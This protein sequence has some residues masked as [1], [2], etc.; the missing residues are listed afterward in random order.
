MKILHLTAQKPD[1]TGSG[2]YLAET[3]AACA[4]AGHEQAVICGIGPDDQP[5][6]PEGVLV[7][8]V[9][10]EIDDLPFPVVGM[11]D[12]MPYPATRYRD[13]TPEMVAQFK[14]EFTRALDDVLARFE[15][16]LT[17][18]NHLYLLTALVAHH[19]VPG[20]LAGLSHG[21][22]I[23]Q[24]EKIPLERAYIAEGVRSLDR[25]F[26]LH[27]AQAEDITRIYGVDADRIRVVGCGFNDR[28][29]K[30]VADDALSFAASGG[31]AAGGAAAAKPD[32]A[33]AGEPAVSTGAAPSAAQ[34][35]SDDG[36]C[37]ADDKA[38]VPAD[39][40]RKPG[41]IVYAGKIW[42]KKGVRSLIR[43]LD[44][45]DP[46]RAARLSVRLAGGYN[47]RDEYESIVEQ[48]RACAVPCTFLGKLPQY[49]L[50]REY[51]AADVFVLPSFFE[52]LPLVVVEALACGCKVVV[53]DL[54]G[55]RPW[56][57]EN[58]PGAPMRY[59]EPPR[60]KNADDPNPEDLPRFERD[61]ARALEQALDDE[62]RTV[63]VSRLSWDGLAKRLI[64][65]R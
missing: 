36:T 21:T 12:V 7:V 32:G 45:I 5:T 58:A 43:A 50:A 16:D 29:F 9:R 55:I 25:V 17:I 39:S 41:T 42:E 14:R 53:T 49:E 18:S 33:S 13:L 34:S 40:G 65:N 57:Q 31:A 6:F 26:A 2:V 30:P 22:D 60:M 64:E 8:P 28:V 59:V 10:F 51:R 23:R 35:A 38:S 27:E 46:A 44:L 63:D 54:P 19:G 62:P 11:S 56:L 24:M 20:R 1:S 47:A 15:P 4:R 3:V 37:A 48:A 61:L 52:G